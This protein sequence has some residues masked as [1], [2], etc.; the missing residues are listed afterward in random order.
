MFRNYLKTAWRNLWRSPLFVTTNIVGLSL[1]FA[2][3]MLIMLYVK[4]DLSFDRFHASANNIYRIV[5]ESREPDGKQSHGS[6]TGGLEGQVFK[7]F[8]PDI[9]SA[10][11]FMGGSDE[12]VMKGNEVFSE[13]VDYADAN[14]F[15]FFSFK[16]LHGQPAAAL[17]QPGKVVISEEIARK[18]F[19]VEN[20]VGKVLRI[21]QNGSFENFL[22]SGVSERSPLNSS[23]RFNILL[24][25]SRV[26]QQDYTRQ[27]FMGILNTFV[28]LDNETNVAA[29]ER[30]I[31][32]VF[33]N[34]AKERLAAIRS[35]FGSFSFNY[36]LQPLLSIHRDKIYTTGNGIRD[37]NDPQYS[38]ILSGIAIFILAIACINFIN[39]SLA[40][41]LKRGKEVGIR[42]VI[43]GSR[44]QLVWQFIGE[45]FLLNILSFI[46]AFLIVY[47]VLPLF[48]AVA[49]KQLETS[50]LFEWST[51][52]LFLGLIIVNA[53]LAGLYP[54]MSFSRF[55]PIRTLSGNV[56]LSGRNYFGRALLVVQFVISICLIVGT[57]VMQRQFGYLMNKNLGFN[58]AGIVNVQLPFSDQ[59]DLALFKN[60][61][62]KQRYIQSAGA[63]SV[64]IT[65]E[66]KMD[67]KTGSTNIP[68]VPFLKVDNNFLS[69]MQ[70]PVV[71][72]RNFY[73]HAADSN[74]CIVNTS[75]VKA[76][77]WS[78]PL[79]K[80][81]QWNGQELN[82]VGV[83]AD[84]HIASLKNAIG[85]VLLVQPKQ[86]MYGELA[87]R[88][89]PRFKV[90]AIT[91][92]QS[93]YKAL[94][95]L[96]PFRYRFV[97]ELIAA[98]YR[99]EERWKNVIT[100]AAVISIFISCIGLFALFSLSIEQ[101]AKEIS[102][103]KVMGSG[104]AG[105]F[106][107][108]SRGFFLM[109]LIASVIA[110]PL[111]AWVMQRWLESFAYRIELQWWIFL[112]AC[113]LTLS[114]GLITIM[115]Q[116]LRAAMANPVKNLRLE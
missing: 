52:C 30:K 29:T 43:G 102:I 62:A 1:G 79:G 50:Y 83:V 107:L 94:I 100:A 109:I 17:D 34:Q 68:A 104:T 8:V 66:N 97:D 110:I 51:L 25:V 114:I 18:Y 61:L 59:P 37:W 80:K 71:A 19:G 91:G 57:L 101:R 116:T 69:I 45:S 7:E 74:N 35:E 63:Q 76:A 55:N 27:W 70:I 88:I 23:L 108:L 14:F 106:S 10:C 54:A 98:Q 41:L 21:H 89:D 75:L 58:A 81:V 9:R 112:F 15:T 113:V 72:G 103:R 38:F 78:E 53:L 82:V 3:V 4:D 56:K 65:S 49:N 12:L 46:P 64:P 86:W 77:G 105:I 36:K 31:Q 60:E 96:Y 93:V 42:K 92:L 32:S 16:L 24:P 39:Q 22:V 2:C 87:V 20:A 44:K 40:R 48:T 73:D 99:N 5:H 28:L 11:R 115:M 6:N 33:E 47:L 26:L 84:F 85:P 95:P 90:E 67:V 111:S 13:Q